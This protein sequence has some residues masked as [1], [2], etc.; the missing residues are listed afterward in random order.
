MKNMK[1]NK[2]VDWIENWEEENETENKLLCKKGIG[3]FFVNNHYKY[4][5]YNGGFRVY[6]G[7]YSWVWFSSISN[8]IS[9]HGGNVS[10]V[11]KYF[12]IEE[13]EE[14]IELKNH[15]KEKKEQFYN[16]H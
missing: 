15:R 11:G 6:C 16:D 7:K 5:T 10:Y 12:D 13:N 8:D 1:K 9:I 4:E 2:D 14:L 3:G